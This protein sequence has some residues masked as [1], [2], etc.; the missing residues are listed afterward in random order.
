MARNRFGLAS[1]AI[2]V[3]SLTL[4]IGCSSTEQG[5]HEN[6]TTTI[7]R[8]DKM[9]H[10]NEAKAPLRDGATG[11]AMSDG[12]RI[13][14]EIHGTGRPL[15]LV[16]GW[17]VNTQLNWKVSGWIDALAHSHQVIALDIRGHGDSDKPHEASR[18]TYAAMSDDVI[19]V[20]EHLGVRHA[21]YMGFSLGAFVGIH[22]LG[23]RP[24]LF[25][26]CVLMGIGDE[27]AETLAMAP[28]V[29]AALRAP[30]PADVHDPEALAYRTI[31]DADPRNDR[32]ALAV[33]AL[34]MWPEG[35]PLK[36]GGPGLAKVDVPV[37]IVNGTNDPYHRTDPKLQAA[38][39]GSEV[40][41]IPGVD[42]FSLVFD[43]R[44]KEAVLPFLAAHG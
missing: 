4:L 31:V 12:L 9:D 33:A 25:T 3:T 35:Y 37:L 16:H 39:P 11:F 19:A 18:Y 6:P 17:G 26:S 10:E 8:G 30:T 40:K 21:D 43:P 44:T 28:R 22:L 36:V 7:P 29:A 5:R 42:H 2:A 14:Y 32:E 13:H 23:H 34:T 1:M 15:V 24:G 27:D 41:E 20:M 38:I